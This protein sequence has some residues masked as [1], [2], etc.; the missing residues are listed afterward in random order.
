M[1]TDKLKLMA[2]AYYS[3]SELQG[4]ILTPKQIRIIQLVDEAGSE[5]LRTGQLARKMQGLSPANSSNSLAK[6]YARGFLTRAR[7]EDETQYA[8]FV[9]ETMEAALSLGAEDESE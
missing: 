6:L 7:C 9:S 1:L 4:F 2:D 3:R 5:G 8:Y